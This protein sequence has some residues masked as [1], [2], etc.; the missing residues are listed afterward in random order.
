MLAI[1]IGT[2]LFIYIYSLVVCAFP[3]FV[4]P[5]AVLYPMLCFGDAA[6]PLPTGTGRPNAGGFNFNVPLF[7]G[8]GKK[9]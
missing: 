4:G 9:Y 8:T 1:Y 6:A 7:C 2:I 5:C 3:P